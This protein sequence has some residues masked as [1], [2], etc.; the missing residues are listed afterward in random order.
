MPSSPLRVA[1]VVGSL[2]A[3]PA[4]ACGNAMNDE[5]EDRD[6]SP[7]H[8]VVLAARKL[9]AY[10]YKTALELARR[11]LWNTDASPATRR[12]ARRVKG[13]A[14]LRLGDCELAVSTLKAALKDARDDPSL[15]APLGQALEALGR[16]GEARDLLV[17]L[18]DKDL[19]PDPASHV[20]L[21]MALN[22]LGDAAGALSEVN[23]AL[24]QDA[25]D[26]DA[27]TLKQKLTRRPRS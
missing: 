10:D 14:S 12:E 17:P 2:L 16:H 20:A 18:R 22:A 24:A 4:L 3:Y 13:V 25:F 27:R 26:E 1:L 8:L 7:D 5:D 11:A 21:A 23:A 15:L 9:K 6:N 19:L